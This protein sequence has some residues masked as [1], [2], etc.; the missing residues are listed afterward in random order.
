MHRSILHA[1]K[2][3]WVS[4]VNPFFKPF[5]DENFLCRYNHKIIV[6]LYTYR[7][8]SIHD[9]HDFQEI[10]AP[11]TKDIELTVVSFQSG[12]FN[13]YGI[14]PK[15]SNQVE[16]IVAILT[17][18]T[19]GISAN[20]GQNAL[21]KSAMV[22]HGWEINCSQDFNGD[23]H[24]STKMAPY[25]N[26]SSDNFTQRWIKTERHNV[27]EAWWAGVKSGFRGWWS[28]GEEAEGQPKAGVCPE[29]E[30]PRLCHLYPFE[31]WHQ[32]TMNG[33]RDRHCETS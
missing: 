28:R 8:S 31:N 26:S 17:I 4:L 30:A 22:T 21:H 16:C 5:D 18:C 14:I 29:A 10:C 32:R 12:Q 13:R 33:V 25:R 20:H 19:E 7:K 9:W 11:G 2:D 3:V 6:K 1:S 27:T 15:I 24:Q 23:L